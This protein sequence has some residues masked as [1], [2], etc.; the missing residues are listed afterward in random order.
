MI[1]KNNYVQY[2]ILVDEFAA[3]ITVR[4]IIEYENPFQRILD[5]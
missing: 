3:Q 2:C 4:M 1:T 5:F